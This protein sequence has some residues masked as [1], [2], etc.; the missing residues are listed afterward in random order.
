MFALNHLIH[1]EINFDYESMLTAGI[2][3][4]LILLCANPDFVVDVGETRE[5]AQSHQCM[6]KWRKGY[7]FGKPHNKI[8]QEVYSF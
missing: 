5:M 2:D 1:Q 7:L 3:K 6:S 8:Y 4:E